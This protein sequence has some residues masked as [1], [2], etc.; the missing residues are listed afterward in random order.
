MK[1]YVRMIGW[2]LI[3]YEVIIRCTVWIDQNM[4]QFLCYSLGGKFQISYPNWLPPTWLSRY[5]KIDTRC[6]DFLYCIPLHTKA[7][8][9]CKNVTQNCTSNKTEYIRV[10]DRIEKLK[11]FLC[12]HFQGEIRLQWHSVSHKR[13]A[14]SQ[15]WFWYYS[16]GVRK[17]VCKKIVRKKIVRKR[18]LFVRKIDSR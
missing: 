9:L 12:I 8:R 4:S 13:I 3:F 1:V 15:N 5:I 16:Y 10:D 2:G 14:Q 18:K 17:I 6:S 11:K 7:Y